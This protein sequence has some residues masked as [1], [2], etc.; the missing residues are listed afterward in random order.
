M[1]LY[2]LNPLH[3]FLALECEYIYRYV[4][5]KTSAKPTALCYQVTDYSLTHYKR[6]NREYSH[7]SFKI[8]KLPVFISDL[9]LSIKAFFDEKV[10]SVFGEF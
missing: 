5:L 6:K 3:K 9:K 7:N 1:F 4:L 8:R 2:P 10:R